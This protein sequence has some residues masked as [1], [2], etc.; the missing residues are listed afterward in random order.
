VGLDRKVT[1]Q[2]LVGMAGELASIQSKSAPL[3]AMLAAYHDL[4][5]VRLQPCSNLI[6]S[7]IRDV[8][9]GIWVPL[10][11]LVG[12]LAGEAQD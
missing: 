11:P 2:A 3:D 10:C 8:T 12:H 4:P 6:S 9:C 1:H 5:P 7:V